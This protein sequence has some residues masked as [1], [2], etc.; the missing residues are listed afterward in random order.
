MKISVIGA[1]TMGAGIAAHLANLDF[2]VKLFDIDTKAAK[3][4]LANMMAAKPA[5]LYA[6]DKAKNISCYSLIED[7][8]ELSDADWI[9][10][11]VFE[12]F[13]VKTD[14]YRRIA[15]Y[16][17]STCM[18]ST[19][20][21][22]L[23]INLL[24][25]KMPHDL[26]KRFMGVHFFN[27]PRYLKLIELIPTQ[28]T[29]RIEIDKMTRFLEKKV[30]RRVV[31]AKDTP[32]FIANRFGMWS[33]YRAVE[34]A[35][36]LMLSVEEVDYLTGPLIGRPKSA[37]FRLND[38]VGLDI[39][40]DI[41]QNIISRCPKDPYI[42]TF[43]N[44]KSIK[45][46]IEKGW[47]GNK[48][49]AGYYKKRGEDL[50]YLDL[51]RIRYKS[52]EKPTHKDIQ[53]LLKLTL[54]DRMPRLLEIDHR[55]GEFFKEYLTS[56]LKYANYLKEE[57]S[58]SISDFDEIMQWGF[59]WEAG[60]FQMIDM[61]G[62]GKILASNKLFYQHQ[63]ILNFSGKYVPKTTK[64]DYKTIDE[65]PLIKKSLGFNIRE[66]DSG[67]KA[68]AL[69]SKMGVLNPDMCKRL[70]EVLEVSPVGCKWVLCSESQA[71][72]AGFNLEFFLTNA[73]EKKWSVINNGLK[74]LQ[75]LSMALQKKRVVAAVHGYCLGAGLEIASA[76]H[77]ILLHPEA[78]LGFP[79]INVGLLPAGA[80]TSRMRIWYQS[81]IT[82]LKSIALQI[83]R[84]AI[85]KNGYDGYGAG[86]IRKTDTILT[87]PDTLISEAIYHSLH[88]DY[89]D[90]D[91]KNWE[92]FQKKEI[93]NIKNDI[94]EVCEKEDISPYS[95][96]ISDKILQIFFDAHSWDEALSLERELFIQ[97]LQNS[98]SIDRIY[99]MLRTGKYLNN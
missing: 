53:L 95:I 44:V 37:S 76:C 5:H 18:F 65:Y 25:E 90:L 52:I 73:K 96:E 99:H 57:I 49:K 2:E 1:G 45:A 22:G 28:F 30:G 72:S 24:A 85:T 43:N 58:H 10:E 35:E 17:S 38:I 68:I 84:G 92:N 55:Y 32:G 86:Y 70:R 98:K 34:L 61:I 36:N 8:N 33:M 15:P 7:L 74:E 80:G 11:A 56:S 19:N 97:L 69:T 14:V 16:I 77:K 39:M 47:I 48:K 63:T 29:S 82:K 75:K 26:K 41:A 6:P 9:C 79:E 40:E 94:E 62:P 4:G 67:V 89:Y 91:L 88:S 81:D 87:H 31:L 71:F 66:L 50:Y 51:K 12:K 23:E 59:G 54:K 64:D 20:T 27:P 3:K 83:I 60:P 78:K 21:S 46:L 13:E 93:S 42:E